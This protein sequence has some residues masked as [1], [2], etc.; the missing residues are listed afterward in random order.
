MFHF[1]AVLLTRGVYTM[2]RNKINDAV[3]DFFDGWSL[4]KK[5]VDH[6][7]MSHKEMYDAVDVVIKNQFADHGF[8]I[9]DL[10]CGDSAFI[11]KVLSKYNVVN[12]TGIDLSQEATK[13][14]LDNLHFIAEKV[15]FFHCDIL[16]A[17][18]QKPLNKERFDVIFSSYALHHYTLQE[19]QEFF[20]QTKN[21]LTKNG[22]L[23]IVDVVL[24]EHQSLKEFF[25]EE[26]EFFSGF[27]ELS[28]SD[29]SGA[30]AHITSA[31]IPETLTTYKQLVANAGLSDFKVAGAEKFFQ[32]FVCKNL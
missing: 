27:P 11:A 24:T 30:A 23:V 15:R 8:T 1:C 17:M 13:L 10:G 3:K 21:L 16:E 25:D 4:Y 32:T 28:A 7:I 12:Y 29:F 2:D 18:Q 14:A 31:D 22:I 9:L 5:F 19:K 6:N 20:N 26:L